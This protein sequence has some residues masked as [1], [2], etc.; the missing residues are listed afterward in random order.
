[1]QLYVTDREAF[2]P[3]RTGIAML[4]T[5][6]RL[7]PDDFA[8]RSDAFDPARPYWIDKLTGSTQVRT[9]IDAGKDAE[10]VEAG[11]SGALRAFAETREKYLLYRGG[12]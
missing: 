4:V 7:Y 8:W 12:N 6:K 1:V 9:D 2:D 10:E 11:W 5:A 3:V